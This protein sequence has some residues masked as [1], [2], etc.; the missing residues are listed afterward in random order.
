MVGLSKQSIVGVW[1]LDAF[2]IHKTNGTFA[3]WG[4]GAHGMLIYTDSGHVSV[5]INRKVEKTEPEEKGFYDSILFYSGT[6]EVVAD[7]ILHE[8]QN[9]SNP[10]RVGRNMIRFAS[11]EGSKQITLKTPNEEW[12]HAVLVWRKI[13]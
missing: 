12:G 10:N 4:D 8:V 1:A 3:P 2:T 7:Q 11:L 13:Q 6:F 5:S 9:A